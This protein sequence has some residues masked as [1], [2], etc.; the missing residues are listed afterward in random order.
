[1]PFFPAGI[2]WFGRT[3][4]RNNAIAIAFENPKPPNSALQRRIALATMA[5]QMGC[6]SSGES[7][8]AR[9]TSEMAA[10][11]AA[12]SATGPAAPIRC[13]AWRPLNVLVS[14]C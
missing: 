7:A 10:S 11:W 5:S 2:I 3:F 12:S 14:N 6:S 9:S 8:M 4:K 13:A 1:M